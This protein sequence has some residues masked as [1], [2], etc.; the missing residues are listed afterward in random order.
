MAELAYLRDGI[1]IYERSSPSSAEADLARFSP[2][3]AGW[4]CA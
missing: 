3:E 4:R 2:A 1:A